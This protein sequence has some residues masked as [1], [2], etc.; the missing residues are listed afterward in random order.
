MNGLY[1]T[2]VLLF[3]ENV[4]CNGGPGLLTVVDRYNSESDMNKE[5]SVFEPQQLLSSWVSGGGAFKVQFTT[6]ENIKKANLI[7]WSSEEDDAV[8]VDPLKV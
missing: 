2:L 7:Y 8:T 6:T 5:F 3:L 1:I 4:F